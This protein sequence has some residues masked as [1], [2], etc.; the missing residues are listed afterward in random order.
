MR[1]LALLLSVVST[2]CL[3]TAP[4]GDEVIGTYAMSASGATRACEL[5]EVTGADFSFEA[6]LTRDSAS[7]RAWV[8]LGT[9]PG[10]GTF[11]GQTLTRVREAGRIFTACSECT[12]T[13]V[14]TIAV[15]VLSRSQADALGGQ[16]PEAPLDGGVPVPSGDAGVTGPQQ[17]S[18]GF[19]AVR[20]CGELTTRVVAAGLSDGGACDAKCDGCTVRYQLRGDRR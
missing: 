19:D 1:R 13:V 4:P 12:T 6:V 14:E 7:D 8:T 16:C 2:G 20:L 9:W 10:E 5:D 11:D 18:R 17:T 15:A 3:V